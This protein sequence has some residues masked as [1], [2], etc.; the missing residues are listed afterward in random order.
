MKNFVSENQDENKLGCEMGNSS[1]CKKP[2]QL[3][4]YFDLNPSVNQPRNFNISRMKMS[5]R[6]SRLARTVLHIVTIQSI[7]TTLRN[8]F[9]AIFTLRSVISGKAKMIALGAVSHKVYNII[10]AVLTNPKSY[11][12]KTPTSS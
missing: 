5:K 8:L 9:Y 6:G 2:K 12:I 1:A 7:A 4:A 10:F 3:F 11:V